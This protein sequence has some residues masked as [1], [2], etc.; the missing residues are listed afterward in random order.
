MNIR[1]WLAWV[2]ACIVLSGCDRPEETVVERDPVSEVEAEEFG[3]QM[4]AAVAS[5]NL[6]SVN[7]LI[8]WEALLQKA[9]EGLPGSETQ[10]ARIRNDFKPSLQ[11]QGLGAEL[12]YTVQQG[13]KYQLLRVMEED[14][15]YRPLLRLILPVGGVN[16][17]LFDL[18][19]EDGDQIRATDVYVFVSAEL[20]SESLRRVLLPILTSAD[21]SLMERLSGRDDVFM[22][23]LDLVEKL[24]QR[25]QARDYPGVLE[26]Y[27]DW[28]RELQTDKN[29]ML[30]RIQAAAQVDMDLYWQAIQDFEATHPDDPAVDL[31]LIDAHMF[32]GQYDESVA[33]ID[34]LDAEVGGDPYL[35]MVKAG[36]LLEK[37]DAEEALRTALEARSK[38]PDLEDLHWMVL[39]AALTADRHQEAADQMTLLEEEFGVEFD[40]VGQEPLYESFLRSPEGQAWLSR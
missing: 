23:N 16:Y 30:L 19:K 4:E 2:V 17:H 37:G 24:M 8:D 12:I 20:L 5:G 28:P 26:V 32:R 27:E 39:T 34:R 3:L 40:A 9:E 25:Y 7:A 31:M 15:V 36:V 13:G 1:L 22:Q 10:K 29:Y 33:A 38:E 21:R 11:Q 35:E 18:G 6:E 14:G